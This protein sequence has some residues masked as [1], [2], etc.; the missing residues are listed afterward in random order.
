M[1]KAHSAVPE[2]V[3]SDL[4]KVYHG[5][6][7]AQTRLY[8]YIEERASVAR[9]LA[10]VAA[11]YQIEFENEPWWTADQWLAWAHKQVER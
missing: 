9:V 5:N 11:R 10:G 4:E 6:K 8:R 3:L 1:K 2:R 7:S